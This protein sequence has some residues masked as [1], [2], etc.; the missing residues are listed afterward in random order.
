MP[1]LY[2]TVTYLPRT[3]GQ[4]V[5][6]QTA[7][8]TANDLSPNIFGIL[9]IF[10]PYWPKFE[11]LGHSD[12]H[13]VTVSY[14]SLVFRHFQNSR[15]IWT[16]SSVLPPILDCKNFKWAWEIL[17]GISQRKGMSRLLLK[18]YQMT[19]T[20][21]NTPEVITCNSVTTKN[22]IPLPQFLR[23]YTRH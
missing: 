20:K 23:D 16:G 10:R 19:L 5:F 17:R 3:M 8:S 4:Y 2:T 21:V 11:E 22:V 12:Q 18:R 1:N 7:C 9:D 15:R 14:R 13:F 6:L